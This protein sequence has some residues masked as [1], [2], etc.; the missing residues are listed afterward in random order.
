M[1]QSLGIEIEGHRLAAVLTHTSNS[2]TPIV[3]LHGIGGSVHFWTPDLT[4]PFRDLGPCYAL[5]LPGHFPAVFP[6]GFPADC[7]TAELIAWLVSSAIQKIV[8]NK[9][10]LLVGHSTG[11][12]AA[13]STAI[14]HPEVVA[15]VVSIAGFSKGQWT[16]ALGF[17]Q[18]LVRLGPIGCATF[19]KVYQLG[20]SHPAIFR[21]YWQAYVNDHISLLNNPHFGTVT[22]CMLPHFRKL[23]LDALVNYFKVMPHTDITPYLSKVSAPTSLIVGDKDPIVPPKQSMTIAEK[24]T[25]A[26]LAIL[27]GAGHLP[28]FERPVEYNRA[29]ETWLVEFQQGN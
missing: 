6:E 17:S 10:V 26:K 23:D 21:M 27:K 2:G 1:D 29:V 9:K 28:F 7:L 25:N 24:V 16:G 20:G 11:G 19:K 4:A 15:G 22:D 3:F 18:W 8:G 13:L 5:S 12:F 14:H